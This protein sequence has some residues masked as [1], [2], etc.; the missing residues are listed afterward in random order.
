MNKQHRLKTIFTLA[1]VAAAGIL[2]A[3]VEAPQDSTVPQDPTS[4]ETEATSATPAEDGTATEEGEALSPAQLAFN[5]M[6][7]EYKA[8]KEAQYEGEEEASLY[9]K[10]MS[11]YLTATKALELA[12]EEEQTTQ[13][14]NVLLDING[15]LLK[16]AF[17]YSNG[18]DQR[19]LANFARAYIDTQ[20]LPVFSESDFKR[21][22]RVYPTLVY[23]AAS[24]A[25]NSGNFDLAKEYFDMYLATGEEKMRH[26]VSTFMGQA[27]INT[28]DYL[29]GI[30]TLSNAA[31]LYPDDYQLV[32]MGIQCCIDGGYADRIQPLLDRA[33][34]MKPGDE[35]LLNVQAQVYESTHDYKKA[36]D[37]Y[38]Q[39]AELHPNSLE[40]TQRIATCYYNLGADFYNKSI[41][42][43]DEKIAKKNR[44]QSRAYFESAAQHLEQIVATKPNDKQYLRALGIA[45]GYLDNKEKFDEI[46]V[47][48][49]ALGDKP[50][51]M[52]EMPEV[53][54]GP[55]GVSGGEHTTTSSIAAPSYQEFAKNYIEERLGDWAK[56]GE[57]EKI[58]DYQKRVTE[59]GLQGEYQKLKA[60]AEKQYLD[61][62][63]FSFVPRDLELQPYD[64]SNETYLITTP[65]GDATIKVPLKNKEA[66]MFKSAW[67]NNN[68][69]I[70]APRYMIDDDRLAIASITFRTT[71]G[72]S[73]SYDSSKAATY[74][75]PDVKIN[76]DTYLKQTTP[77][78]TTTGKPANAKIL[79]KTSDVDKDIP[80]TGKKNTNTYAFIVAN[81]NY[82][83]VANVAS[84]LHDGQTF[85]EYCEK[86]LGI[87]KSQITFLTDATSGDFWS[88]FENLKGRISNRPEDVDVI[89][90]YS[91][92]GLPDDNTKEAYLMPVDAQPQHSRT[93][94][95]LQEVY[96][97]LG[98]LPNASVYAFMDA[99]FSG[100]SRESGQK[101]TP[102]VAARGVALRH[103]D[104]DPAGNVFVL[105]A[106]DAQQ[107]AFPYEDKDHGMFTYWLLKKLQE[108]KG[109]A[110][111]EDISTYVKEKVA[112]TSQEI[113]RRAQT[114]TYKATGKLSGT[115]K[116]K[117]LRP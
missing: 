82:K 64:P 109:G 104:V 74:E 65:Y 90:Y 23:V 92:H 102:V 91:G 54:N 58:E 110:T 117:K 49:G 66:E 69:E 20:R 95:K 9:P 26:Q 39:I 11:M 40:N 81:E 108:S 68:V 35:Q 16:G 112:S 27:C 34:L 71:A 47:R 14:K 78:Q 99:C 1:A 70:R 116:S 51:A 106:A 7:E 5:A 13:A 32:A 83:N 87:P 72:K 98:K 45:Y 80:E 60:E 105:S 30:N 85:S 113:N 107:T 15:L 62:Y 56:R 53:M 63:A 96:D 37:M 28:K 31:V 44:R 42:E 88:E 94:I 100:S 75:T 18:G 61:K 17:F 50:M 114:P 67:N 8:L 89:L 84:A 73:Y 115:W 52:G 21:D 79:A 86:T 25:Y 101:D 57:F 55:L 97:G 2:Y 10:V 6:T 46:N 59:G 36:L 29:K 4:T 76:L 24:D 111:L 103:K 77:T 3:S 19:Q 33:L 41:M 12:E 48:L 93:M 22:Q 43:E 38:N